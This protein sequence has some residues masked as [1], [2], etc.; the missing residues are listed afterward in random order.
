ME[1]IICPTAAEAAST[2]A[3]ILARLLREK[4]DATLGLATGN[5]PLALYA[6][7]IRRHQSGAIDFAHCHAFNL[8][9]YFGIGPDHPASYHRFMSENL[10]SHINIAPEHCRIP[11][12]LAKDV[13]TACRD[14]EQA[15]VA[16][17]GI[18]LQVLGIGGDGHIGFNEP[19]S[20]LQSRTRI[21]TL[22]ARTRRD[23]AGD[24]GAEDNVPMHVITMGVGTIMEARSLLLF[25]FGAHKAA[26]VA[27]AVEGPITS[28]VP[29]SIL[30]MHPCAKV[31][32]DEA[33]A[34][35]LTRAEYYRWVYANKP[36]WQAD[37]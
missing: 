15:I 30:Q 28:M 29:A 10:F 32:L 34:S 8:D 37:A 25:A 36:A 33:A 5:T 21:K 7:L 19:G 20:S 23:N 31:I 4:P 18:D 16:S 26:V 2:G 9:E 6:E 12:G 27:S 14:Y 11:D 13:P 3:S 17:G 22:T 24:F 35:Q 1:V